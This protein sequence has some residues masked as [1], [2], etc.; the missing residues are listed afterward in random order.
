MASRR[1]YTRRDQVPLGTGQTLAFQRGRG[2]YARGDVLPYAGYL[3]PAQQRAEAARIAAAA[4]QP[5]L[6]SLE[7]ERDRAAE[8]NRLEGERITGSAAGLAEVLKGIAPQT[9]ATYEQAA[10]RT[11]AF[12]KGYS[13]AMQQL[14]QQSADQGNALLAQNNSPQTIAPTGGSDAL[15]ALT[16]YLPASSLTREGAAF[17]AAAR[18]LPGLAAGRG[19]Q[20]LAANV[21][22][23][24]DEQE[25]FSKQRLQLEQQRGA[26][27]SEALRSLLQQQV[28]LRSAGIQEQY[29]ANTLRQ[30]DASITG[31]DPYTGQPTY[32]AVSD[33]AEAAADAA[34]ARTKAQKEQRAAR[35]K[36]RGNRSSALSA[37]GKDISAASK[38]WL[39]APMT[40]PKPGSLLNPGKYL[41]DK[42][43]TVAGKRV[44]KATDNLAEAAYENRLTYDQAYA[45]AYQLIDGDGLK[46][47]FRLR[48][49]E[50][51]R[52]I[53]DRLAAVGIV[54]A[55]RRRRSHRP[56]GAD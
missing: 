28:D 52:L 42:Y 1:F 19:Q 10:N 38:D 21:R 40:N 47:R 3:S 27:Q 18:Q 9:Q 6:S 11:A 48:D 46:A 49:Y 56:G 26:A 43:I 15:Y 36:A 2:Y 24:R 12:G 22:A 13:D 20:D 41:T 44:R 54:P 37:A 29:L 14:Q 25:L 31:I 30:T 39:G 33:A 55:R 17:T 34:A 32:A 35:T 45:R 16:G 53:R 51:N 23:G 4:L 8:R 5:Q 50:V 7:M